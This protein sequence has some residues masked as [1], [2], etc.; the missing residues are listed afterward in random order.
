M[1]H[2]TNASGS[3]VTTIATG[4]EGG[5]LPDI[6]LDANQRPVIA[7]VAGRSDAAA[8]IIVATRTGSSWTRAAA[9]TDGLAGRPGVAFRG[10]DLHLVSI[11]PFGDAINDGELVHVAQE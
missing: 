6:T 2:V 8:P 11:L 4:A 10:T 7:Y 3:W 5:T 1:L 9:T